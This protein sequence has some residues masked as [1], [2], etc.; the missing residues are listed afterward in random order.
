MVKIVTVSFDAIVATQAILSIG[1]QVRLHKIRL[2]LLMAGAAHRLIELGVAIDMAGVT[3]KRRT[4][5]LFLV[6][7]E[8]KP[9][10]IV[11]EIRH[12]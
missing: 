11:R 8:G 7:S 4:V 12:G 3:G 6:G 9:K 2:D 5:R 10:H 1:L